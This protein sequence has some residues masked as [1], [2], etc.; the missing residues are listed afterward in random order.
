[1][2]N[3]RRLQNN[4]ST[5]EAAGVVDGDMISV[6]PRQAAPPAASTRPST[7]PQRASTSQAGGD[8]GAEA[9]TVR[10]QALGDPRIMQQIRNANA[11]L[12][13]AINDPP[14]F[15][16]LW[17]ALRDSQREHAMEQDRRDQLLDA[18]PFDIEAQREIEERIRQEQVE[19]NLEL[20]MEYSPEGMNSLRLS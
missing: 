6:V 9:E 8:L 13:E 17:L 11:P 7:Q 16:Q 1:M 10:L 2:C 20:A 12:A 3:N 4:T 15:A 14:R 19:K 5:L 18:D